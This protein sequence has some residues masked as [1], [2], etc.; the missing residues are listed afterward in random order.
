MLVSNYTNTLIA[1]DLSCEV[2]GFCLA[3]IVTRAGGFGL[4]PTPKIPDAFHRKPMVPRCHTT[5]SSHLRNPVISLFEKLWTWRASVAFHVLFSVGLTITRIVLHMR[6]SVIFLL[7]YSGSDF[8][9]FVF[10]V[11]EHHAQKRVYQLHDEE[12]NRFHVG[13]FYSLPLERFVTSQGTAA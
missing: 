13:H 10:H 7:F 12:K 6:P 3:L 8:L 4:R 11:G 9:L 5:L 1:W 2:S